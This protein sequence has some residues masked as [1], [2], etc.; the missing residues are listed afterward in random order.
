FVEFAL[1]RLRDNLSRRERVDDRRP[2]DLNSNASKLLTTRWRAPS[3]IAS[4]HQT[5]EWVRGMTMYSATPSPHAT[6]IG[7]PHLAALPCDASGTSLTRLPASPL[8]V[9]PA[10][11]YRGGHAIG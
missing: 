10:L 6:E 11:N 7:S 8:A 2:I 5:P 3:S 9:A 1:P 4:P